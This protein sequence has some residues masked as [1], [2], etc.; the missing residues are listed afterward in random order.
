MG[1]VRCH[2]SGLE[3]VPLQPT[4]RDWSAH[5]DF[6]LPLPKPEEQADQISG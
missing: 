1:Q 6:A 4:D 3:L 5:G 2:G